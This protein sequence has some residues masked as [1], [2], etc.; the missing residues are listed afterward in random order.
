[1]LDLLGILSVFTAFG[2]MCSAISLLWYAGEYVKSGYNDKY[3]KRVNVSQNC[4][5]VFATLSLV[6]ILIIGFIEMR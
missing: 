6:L 1:M 3:I 4:L 5:Y 2:L